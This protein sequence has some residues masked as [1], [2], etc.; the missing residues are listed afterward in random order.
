[1]RRPLIFSMRVDMWN[2]FYDPPAFLPFA[3]YSS[4]NSEFAFRWLNEEQYPEDAANSGE[5]VI[6]M[7]FP[8]GNLLRFV[9]EAPLACTVVWQSGTIMLDE[10][11]ASTGVFDWG[12]EEE[13]TV[14]PLFSPE[15]GGDEDPENL[16]HFRV[17]RVRVHPW[18]TI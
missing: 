1:M 9:L 4:N 5:Q 2:S 11:G 18:T 10:N 15:I 13:L 17:L 7:L 6:S 3:Y 12:D 14:T 8:S 16:R